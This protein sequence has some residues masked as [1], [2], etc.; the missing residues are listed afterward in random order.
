MATVPDAPQ[1][2]IR[3]KVNEVSLEFFWAPPLSDGGDSIT[4]Y[5][6]YDLGN[7]LSNDISAPATT[8]FVGGLTTGTPYSFSITASNSIG[9]GPA[10]EFRTVQVGIKPAGPSN[11]FLRPESS[12]T[13]TLFYTL[14]GTYATD[15]GNF[16]TTPGLLATVVCAP[17][18]IAGK[19]QNPAKNFV[20]KQSQF[21]NYSTQTIEVTPGNDYKF[22]VRAVNDPGYSPL[23]RFPA[24]IDL[25]PQ[26]ISTNVIFNNFAP[27]SS[28]SEGVQVIGEGIT[29]PL[30]S[31]E[32]YGQNVFNYK[33]NIFGHVNVLSNTT[34][35]TSK[36]IIYDKQ[37]HLKHITSSIT[38][39]P[40]NL[41]GRTNPFFYLLSDA[42]SGEF[43]YCVYDS[44]HNTSLTSSFTQT[45]YSI[46][47]INNN[48]ENN[49]FFRTYDGGSSA[50]IQLLQ[51]SS[52]S[53]LY[54][55]YIASERNNFMDKSHVALTSNIDLGVYDNIVHI[56]QRA[57]ALPNV[58][59][60]SSLGIGDIIASGEGYASLNDNKF[61]IF[62]NTNQKLYTF[63][64]TQ[65]SESALL[66]EQ[67]IAGT[68]SLNLNYFGPDLSNYYNGISSIGAMAYE[69][70]TNTTGYNFY[71]PYVSASRT[72]VDD[73]N[74][75]I[76]VISP[77]M[78][79]VIGS[80]AIGESIIVAVNNNGLIS[81][82]NLTD[83]DDVPVNYS[84]F[85]NY[86]SLNYNI[87]SIS[88]QINDTYATSTIAYTINNNFELYK[89]SFYNSGGNL[90]SYTNYQKSGVN[91]SLISTSVFKI[92]SNAPPTQILNVF[93]SNIYQTNPISDSS[94]FIYPGST[95]VDIYRVSTLVSTIDFGFSTATTTFYFGPSFWYGINSDSNLKFFY[96]DQ[97][98]FYKSQMEFGLSVNTNN[99]F[100]SGFSFNYNDASSLYTI[101][102]YNSTNSTFKVAP[103]PAQAHLSFNSTYEPLIA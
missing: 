36:L 32:P 6:L 66:F 29:P 82:F 25:T 56:S 23:P 65:P 13:A 63:D 97:N 45:S 70:S 98:G 75:I 83:M 74:Y 57:G 84:A 67:E 7:S 78:G 40:S 73:F 94:L 17:E 28:V 59:N 76:N 15:P 91:F 72:Y 103:A 69:Q 20:Q 80:N 2:R 81:S 47:Y 11:V 1:I 52:I 37:G 43:N 35:G 68:S 64:L 90:V 41:V 55:G 30:T 24:S 26:T 42:G 49:P 44:V 16:P 50:S 77:S 54:T 33:T 95:C 58:I 46:N 31:G 9:Q 51:P 88:L 4:S 89:S 5:Q 27:G 102:S 34:D 92:T 62:A 3:P 96:L 18:E 79:V 93:A 87:S 71:S 19:T 8:G 10:V 85:S 86:D 60:I 22:I 61:C 39:T 14:P 38:G 99:Y 101:I 53:T 21:P 12:S 48:W 100:D